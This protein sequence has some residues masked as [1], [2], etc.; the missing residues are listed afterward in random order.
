MNKAV[1]LFHDSAEL[2]SPS[3][4]FNYGIA[5]WRGNGVPCSQSEAMK[6]FLLSA[7]QGYPP[8]EERMGFCNFYGTGILINHQQAF[9]WNKKAAEHDVKESQFLLALAYDQGLGTA[10][11]HEMALTWYK[12]AAEQNDQRAQF[13]LAY[14]FLKKTDAASIDEG[15]QLLKKSA[16]A[17]YGYAQH[18]LA[19]FFGNGKYIAK[20]KDLAIT[21]Y[22]KA[23]E[24]GIPESE[25]LFGEI[26]FSEK[27]FPEGAEWVRKA[28][29]KGLPQAYFRYG[30]C[31]LDG[32][33]VKKDPAEAIQWFRCGALH[34][35]PSAQNALGYAYFVGNGVPKDLVE[36]YTWYLL[37]EPQETTPYIKQT[38]E[39]NIRNILPQLTTDQIKEAKE[40]ASQFIPI[41][42]NSDIAIP[43][44]IKI[45]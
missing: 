13:N 2:G 7:N 4:Q 19:G 14:Y 6:W 11:D 34:G 23:A 29:V 35:N 12:K 16:D 27:K 5:L 20:N 25:L 22:Q 33:G 21:L 18:Y 42:E 8:A 44:W 28:V 15:M 39:A 26:L 36:A 38:I 1:S 17:G 41:K 31:Y 30:I 9:Y 43:G 32:M 10:Q 40:K 37:A 45:G 24:Q 3:A